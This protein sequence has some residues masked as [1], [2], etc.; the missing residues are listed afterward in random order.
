ME[1]GNGASSN[2]GIFIPVPVNSDVFNDSILTQLQSAYLF[3]E[4]KHSFRYTSAFLIKNPALED[5]YNA[6]REKRREQGYSDKDLKETYGFL[7]FDQLNKVKSIGETGLIAENGTCTTLGDPTKG[8]YLSMYSDCLDLNCWYH[9]K[10]GYI[11]IVKITAG[12][13]KKVS[14]NYTQNLT[15]PTVGFDCHVSEQLPSVSSKTSSFLAFERTQYYLYELLDN[16]STAL[17]PSLVCPYAV[18]AFSYTDSKVTLET[19]QK[20]CEEKKA[21]CPYSPWM[22]K[23]QIGAQIFDIGIR[24]TA[25]AL[26]WAKLSPIIKVEY[27]ISMLILR[28]LLPKAIFETTFNG[29]ALLEHI[30]CSLC[31]IVALSLEEKERLTPLLLEIKKQDAALV[32]ALN[33]GGFLVLIH[34]SNFILHDKDN[35][36]TTNKVLQGVFVFPETQITQRDIKTE[37]TKQTVP[38]DALRVLPLLSYAEGEIEKTSIKPNED[39]CDVIVQHMQSYATLISPGL[40]LS[41]L[42]E[43]DIF[44]DQYDV[45]DDHQ[46]LYSTPEWTDIQWQRLKSYFSNA[47]SFQLPVCKASDILVAGQEA[48]QEELEDDIYICLSSPEEPSTTVISTES[49]DRLDQKCSSPIE[50]SQLLVPCVL[51]AQEKTSEILD[52]TVFTDNSDVSMETKDMPLRTVEHSEELIV[53]ITSADVI[54]QDQLS[55]TAKIQEAAFN[56]IVQSKITLNCSDHKLDKIPQGHN[57][58]STE[59]PGLKIVKTSRNKDESICLDVLTQELSLHEDKCEIQRNEQESNQPSSKNTKSSISY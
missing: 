44:P 58:E 43:V 57:L 47:N 38:S 52:S 55:V 37:R 50:T 6:C 4:S 49:E 2:T 39:L 34:D 26:A 35:E 40:P 54:K 56:E 51:P 18:V 46:H 7:L 9:G 16:G 25:G 12:R 48:Q 27:A 28:K 13:I 53:S 59:T 1:S 5:K 11:A 33:D 19:Q 32:I 45:L 22:G 15:E 21:A 14:E 20:N 17:S 8:V 29:Q 36:I 42:R 23:L 31:E 41:P 3:E 30:F 24:S 10:S